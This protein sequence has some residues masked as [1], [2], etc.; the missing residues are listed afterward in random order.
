[1]VLEGWLQLRREA[2]VEGTAL[3]RASR[4]PVC[5]AHNFYPRII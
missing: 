5:E 1:M 4:D 3:L 2:E